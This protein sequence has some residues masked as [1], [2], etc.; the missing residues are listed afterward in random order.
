MWEAAKVAGIV[1]FAV[2]VVGV[3]FAVH[4]ARA[5]GNALEKKL[6]QNQ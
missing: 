6:N 4:A 3:V 2:T 1:V 5:L